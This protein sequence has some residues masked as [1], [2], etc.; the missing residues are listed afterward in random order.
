MLAQ[1]LS[2]WRAQGPRPDLWLF[3]YASLIWRPE[4]EA[5]EQR[6]ARVHGHHRSLQMWSRVNRA[7]RS[8]QAWCSP[9]SAAA[10]ARGWPCAFPMTMCKR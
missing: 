2:Q 7:H 5:T 6:L 10:V 1:T 8:A 4:F 3:A 9:W